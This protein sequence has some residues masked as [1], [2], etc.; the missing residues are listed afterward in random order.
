LVLQHK[1]TPIVLLDLAFTLSL[2][3]P[4]LSI[5]KHTIS[6][7]HLFSPLLNPYLDVALLDSSL[8]SFPCPHASP[9]TPSTHS[10]HSTCSGPHILI[11]YPS[12]FHLL[13]LRSQLFCKFISFSSTLIPNSPTAIVFYPSTHRP[14]LIRHMKGVNVIGTGSRL[15][16]RRRKRES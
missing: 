4:T 7:Q 6:S 12:P 9:P 8:P 3:K 14:D 11:G 16:E 5:S 13:H 1:L 2:L 15:L 10:F